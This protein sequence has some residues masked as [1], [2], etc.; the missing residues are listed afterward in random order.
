MELDDDYVEYVPVAKRRAM[1]ERKG[2]VLEELEDKEKL[3]SSL[4][5]KATQQLKRRR[6][7]SAT[8]KI[9]LQEKEMMEQLSSDKKTLTS[10]RE[11]AKGITYAEPL[12]TGWEPHARSIMSSKQ[13]DLIRKQCHITVSGKD[14]P[15]PIK[16]FKD[17][18]IPRALLVT[19]KEKGI[20]D[21]N[22]I[23]YKNQSTTT[24]S[25]SCLI[26]IPLLLKNPDLVYALTS[27]TPGNLAGQD[28]VKLLDVTKTGAP[29]LSS[30]SYKEV[31]V[32]LP[33]T[34]PG[35]SRLEQEVI[36]NLFSSQNQVGSV[37][38]LQPHDVSLNCDVQSYYTV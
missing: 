32:S 34:N 16:N 35:M 18:N 15:P 31:E 9:I 17:M 5:V 20:F 14:I 26:L 38:Q 33:S 21:Y 25:D 30:S 7:V 28:K 4:L 23:S 3:A 2:K 10:V 24:P 12:F 37:K 13:I 11:L 27:G 6:D 29:N 22:Y 36:R 19:L 1:Q 8:E